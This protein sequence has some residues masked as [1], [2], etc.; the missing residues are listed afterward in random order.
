[1]MSVLPQTLPEL[2]ARVRR[3]LDLIA[4]P[5]APWVKPHPAP[6]GGNALDVLIVGGGQSGIAIGFGLKRARV[7]NVLIVDKADEGNEGPWRSYARMHTLRSPKDFTGPDLDVPS[8]TYEA[9]HVARFGQ[10]DWDALALIPRELWADYLL[11]VRRQVGLAVQ[12]RTAVTALADAGHGLVAATLEQDGRSRTVFA[13]K[14]VLA[15]GQEC[16]GRWAAPAFLRPLPRHLWAVTDDAIAPDAYAGKVVAVLGAGASA[17]DNAATALEGGAAEVHLFCRRAEPQVIQ[18]YR[19]LTFAGFMRHIGEMDDAWRWR[20]MSHIMGL[21]EGFPQAT[22]DRCATHPNFTLRVGETWRDAHVQ[23]GR[24]CLVTERG[25]F[26]ADLA[27]AC[28][29]IEQDF[30]LRPELSAF[31]DNIATWAERFTPPPQERNDRLAAFPYLGDDFAFLPKDAT[32]TPWMR[33]VHLFAIGST[34][35]QGPSGSSINAMTTMV[36]KMVHALTR[37]LFAGDIEAYWEDLKAYDLPQAVVRLPAAA[38]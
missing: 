29:G 30:A 32:R 33:N 13:R 34:M 2:E 17:F 23:D 6:D 38:E 1:M 20:F 15:T 25:R 14:V 10:A 21:R 24:L 26:T 3:D 11:W 19:W 7:D 4:H 27:I 22:Y 8:L 12:N 37:A 35:S 9:W 31:A 28:V 18:P 5:R 36:P 16:M